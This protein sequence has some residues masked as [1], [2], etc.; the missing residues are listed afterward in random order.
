MLDSNPP[1][2]L[3]EPPLLL[4]GGVELNPPYKSS[5]VT[6]EMP[7]I[8]KR[9]GNS[10]EQAYEVDMR[11]YIPSNN[12]IMTK[13]SPLTAPIVKN[14]KDFLIG[15]YPKGNR[16]L[17]R[18]LL[19]RLIIQNKDTGL[20]YHDKGFY[21]IHKLKENF[22]PITTE[23]LLKAI[24]TAIIELYYNRFRVSSIISDNVLRIYAELLSDNTYIV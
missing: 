9:V 4:F 10:I 3:F 1:F 18:I 19:Q 17:A 13:I 7:M 21:V 24:K 12:V 11:I 6:K 5:D 8:L 22:D 16:K 2:Y 23:L 15:E 20:F 14:C